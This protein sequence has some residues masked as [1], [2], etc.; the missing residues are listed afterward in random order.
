MKNL[1]MAINE[2]IK[3]A[4][5]EKGWSM[6]ELARRVS[7]A[8]GLSKPLSWQTVQQWERPNGT[9]PKLK[10]LETVSRLL[11]LRAAMLLGMS[12]A[13]SDPEF[14]KWALQARRQPIRM[15]IRLAADGSVTEDLVDKPTGGVAIATDDPDSYAL[16]CRG[17]GGY[18]VMR[19]GWFLI[20]EP[21]RGPEPAEY[22]LVTLKT[23]ERYLKEYLFKRNGT[24]ELLTIGGDA[25]SVIREADVSGLEVVAALASPATWREGDPNNA[26]DE[27]FSLPA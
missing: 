7:E 13:A 10:R 24:I 5:L 3:A 25:R 12:E 19:D 15:A 14:I 17:M 22:V 4:R 18:P 8:E 11:G 20:L 23:G 2:M 26:N 6:E 21:S 1:R 27:R 9:A 16:Q